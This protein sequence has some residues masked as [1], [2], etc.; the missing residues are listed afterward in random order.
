MNFIS[1]FTNDFQA[2]FPELFLISA[3]ILLLIYGVVLSTSNRYD[4]P[5]LV[6]NLSWLGIF[7]LGFTFVLLI[8][9]PFRNSIIFYNSLLIDPFACFLKGLIIICSICAI[10]MSLDY[11]KQKSFHAFEYI[12]LILFSTSSM[13]IMVSVYDFL[14]MYLAIE[15]Q[16]LCF[17][18]LAASKRSSEFSTEAGL[19]YFILS[20]FASGIILFGCSMIYGLTGLTNFGELAIFFTGNASMPFHL[21][22]GILL[23]I[24]FISVGLLFKLTAAPFHMW[25]P[26]VYEGSPTPITSFFAIVPKLAI[27]GLFIRFLLF[28]C[29]DLMNVWQSIIVFCSL[30]SM[31]IGALAALSQKRI[32]RMLA[33]SS[34]GHIGYLLMGF[35]CGTIDGVQSLL[36]YMVIY[37][38]MTIGAFAVVLSLQHQSP[39]M[40]Y[41]EDFSMLGKMNPIVAATMSMIL[42]SMAG[43]PPL[44]GF[45]G[46]YYVFLA[47]IENGWY[48]LA[49]IGVLTS[50]ISCFYYIRIMKIMYF[51]KRKGW[52]YT[53]G[54]DREKSIILA[55]TLFFLCFFF[56]APSPLLVV[57]HKIALAFCV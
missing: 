55:I 22:S 53:Q 43:I 38:F 24:L 47:G 5:V 49:L 9:S 25:A 41:I 56:F 31:M 54:I 2:V 27:L 7:S 23:G 10:L 1:L 17:Y 19:K 48:W 4:Y 34:I 44:A 50:V 13:L 51:E 36:L 21:S 8:Q 46:K 32:K 40:K 52:I 45:F 29:Y 14:S 30:A 33:F 57:T 35:A 18:V 16:S 28:S 3:T 11:L 37:S 42:F 12:V 39:S 6:G 20:A 15:L 26:D